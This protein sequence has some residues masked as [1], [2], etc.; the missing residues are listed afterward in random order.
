MRLTAGIGICVTIV[1]AFLA[2]WNID[3]RSFVEAFA[4]ANYALVA[5]AAVAWVTGYA[6][7]SFRWRTILGPDV[8]VSLGRVAKVLFI[9]FLANN[10]LPARIGEFVRAFVLSKVAATSKSFGLAT[11]LIER[12]FDGLA[13]L[14]LLVLATRIFRPPNLAVEIAAIT[15]FA[16]V[17]FL[18]L[19]FLV[20]FALARRELLLR[21][22]ELILSRMPDRVARFGT[23]KSASFLAGLEV[24]RRP[25]RAALISVCSLA[26]W[27]IEALAYSIVL[28]AFDV[29]LVGVQWV[30]APLLMVVVINLG[31]MLPSAPGHL[32]SFHF[33]GK[34][35]L[36]SAFG[37]EDVNALAIVVVAHA[38]QYVLVTGAGLVSSAS[39]SLTWSSLRDAK[40]G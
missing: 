31:I 24:M 10:I 40:A 12:M 34:L 18:A 1:L 29:R 39:E 17:V 11:I 23:E 21:L 14:C 38:V 3:L 16:G 28:M 27:C 20:V 7:R 9:G 25:E 32:G 36:V 30:A 4:Q 26:I 13:L 2:V 33:F 5:L 15:T 22:A 35:A 19:L 8:D 6:I 37:I